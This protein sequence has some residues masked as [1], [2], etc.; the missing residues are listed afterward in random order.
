MKHQTSNKLHQLEVVDQEIFASLHFRLY[1][2]YNIDLEAREMDT[3]L[4]RP[5]SIYA[6]G[7][8]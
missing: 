3:L 7:W 4:Q 2:L 5:C 6:N 8:P 1:I